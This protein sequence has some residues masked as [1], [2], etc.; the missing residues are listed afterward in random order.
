MLIYFIIELFISRSADHSSMLKVICR[1]CGVW[2]EYN[3]PAVKYKE[4]FENKMGI[5]IDLDDVDIRGQAIC[6][7][8]VRMQRNRHQARQIG[9][10]GEILLQ[11]HQFSP[12]SETNCDVC[13]T[14]TA[15]KSRKF[16]QKSDKR[17]T[18]ST[19]PVS[20]S[21]QSSTSKRNLKSKD[22][23]STSSSTVSFAPKETKLTADD[24]YQHF[25]E[26]DATERDIFL[27]A[28]PQLCTEEER[29]TL[30]RSLGSSVEKGITQDSMSVSDATSTMQRCLEWCLKMVV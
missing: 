29:T 13:E 7:N 18:P 11:A 26:M 25:N 9:N 2:T 21:T 24:F 1:V 19:L 23:P 6:D 27:K 28:L 8:H 5:D 4:L 17:P 22:H 20:F 16:S 15:R 3:Y 12:H 14:A 10:V 30:A